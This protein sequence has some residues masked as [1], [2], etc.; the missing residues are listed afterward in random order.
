MRAGGVCGGLDQEEVDDGGQD[1]EERHGQERLQA[2][3]AALNHLRRG[4]Q[5]LVLYYSCQ[6]HRR[7]GDQVYGDMRHSESTSLCDCDAKVLI[8]AYTTTTWMKRSKENTR[9]SERGKEG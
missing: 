8:C 5:R 1:G 2:T 7:P 4:S 6:L 3:R 9:L